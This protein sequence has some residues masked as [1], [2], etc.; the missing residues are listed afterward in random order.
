VK[1]EINKKYT[2]SKPPLLYRLSTA[3]SDTRV[4][5]LQQDS[6][7]IKEVSYHHSVGFGHTLRLG[8]HNSHLL[9]GG[10]SRWVQTNYFFSPWFLDDIKTHSNH[11]I[12]KTTYCQKLSWIRFSNPTKPHSHF[13]EEVSQVVKVENPIPNKI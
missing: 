4:V 2:A 9:K 6:S 11:E 10:F 8:R 13:G 5:R 1:Y 12:K 3:N 7:D